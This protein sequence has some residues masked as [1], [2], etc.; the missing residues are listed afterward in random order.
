MGRLYGDRMRV[1]YLDAARPADQPRVK[2]LLEHVS[3]RYMFYPM[4]F[5]GDELV[6]AGSAEYYEVLYAVRD[7][8]RAEQR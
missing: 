6:M 7:A 5:I 3:G 1:D 2:A 8:L 4:V